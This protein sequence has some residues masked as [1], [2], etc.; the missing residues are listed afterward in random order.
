LGV[1]AGVAVGGGKVW[2]GGGVI[3]SWVF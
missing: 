1:A 3:L 2:A